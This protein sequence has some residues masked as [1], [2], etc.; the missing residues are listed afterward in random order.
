[1]ARKRR[2]L[3]PDATVEGN[4]QVFD[5]DQDTAAAAALIGHGLTS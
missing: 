1:M 5:H 3:G 2:R 4:R